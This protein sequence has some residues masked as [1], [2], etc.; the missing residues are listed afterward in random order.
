MKATVGYSLRRY[1]EDTKEN[2]AA[3][4]SSRMSDSYNQKA[5]EAT[6]FGTSIKEVAPAR[7]VFNK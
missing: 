7:A 3:R 5:V 6:A 4:S 1:L 2:A